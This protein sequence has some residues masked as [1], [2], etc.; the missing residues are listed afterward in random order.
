VSYVLV[1]RNPAR[2]WALP[3]SFHIKGNN[4][5]NTE[6]ETW[7]RLF[8]YYSFKRTEFLAVYHRRSNAESTFSA[9]KRKFGDFVRSK[10]PT[11]QINELLLKVLA[12]NITMIIHSMHELGISPS[13]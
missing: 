5:G 11:A 12:H 1:K 4:R 9:I 2:G 10:T 6:N 8:H 3:R 7:N 13:F